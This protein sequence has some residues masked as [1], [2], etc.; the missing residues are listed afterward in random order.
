M[1]HI[2]CEWKRYYEHDPIVDRPVVEFT[3]LELKNW[4][5]NKIITGKLNKKQYYNM[6]IIIRQSLEYL[7][8]F[9]ELPCNHFAEF[10]IKAS[11]FTTVIP[12]EAQQEVFTEE[13]EKKLKELAAAEFAEHPNRTA[14]HAVLINFSL[15]CVWAS[16]LPFNGRT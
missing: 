9:G 10:K 13:E 5:R 7:V 1:N 6:A 8:E 16:L 11:L 15:V 14:A 3:T 2:D 12:K 4:A